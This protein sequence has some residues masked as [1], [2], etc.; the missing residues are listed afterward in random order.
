MKNKRLT[1]QVLI[2]QSIEI[3]RYELTAVDANDPKAL[4][5]VMGRLYHLYACLNPTQIVE[6]LKAAD[7]RSKHG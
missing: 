5:D 6:V 3:V 2:L 1:D 7:V 4:A